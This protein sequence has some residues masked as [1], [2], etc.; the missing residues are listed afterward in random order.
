MEDDQNITPVLEKHLDDMKGIVKWVISF[1]FVATIL[2]LQ[3]QNLIKILSL[4]LTRQQALFVFSA[5]YL[6]LCLAIWENL[7]R[8]RFHIAKSSISN[9]ERVF[10]DIASHPWLFNPFTHYIYS[11]RKITYYGFSGLIV[12]FSL[13][14]SGVY[15]LVPIA[16][17]SSP[18]A[19]IWRHGWEAWDGMRSLKLLG[20]NILFLLPIG[21]LA[22]LGYLVVKEVLTIFS[23]AKE[24]IAPTKDS[25]L[26]NL[27]IQVETEIRKAIE[28]GTIIGVL[29]FF[30]V[31]VGDGIFTTLPWLLP[32]M[33]YL[34]YFW[35]NSLSTS[36]FFW[37]KEKI[38]AT[39]K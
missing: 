19:D 37:N 2:A 15:I 8:M 21:I 13:C 5:I 3:E 39:M 34:R 22:Y 9:L 7:R 17:W 23:E 29:L 26:E 18:L 11:E 12:C 27:L 20:K 10:Q 25:R 4:E 38:S 31:I 24:R 14:F 36:E 6:F 28:T 33:I 1:S 16:S 32:A 30:I 35:C